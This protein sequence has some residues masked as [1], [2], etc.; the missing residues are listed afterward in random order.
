M[1]ELTIEIPKELEIGVKELKKEELNRIVCEALKERLSE[2]LMFKIA[3]DLLK[4]SRLT[5]D[6]A[7]KLGNELKKR[8][9]KR[10]GL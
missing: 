10:Y 3:D 9:A 7:S 5:D 2:E 1:L 4:E 6:F 8:V